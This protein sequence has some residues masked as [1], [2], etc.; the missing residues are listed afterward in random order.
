AIY[1]TKNIGYSVLSESKNK[2]KPYAF[3]KAFDSSALDNLSI[4]L[5][6]GR[7]PLNDSEILIP[8]HL[9]TNGR[10]E[11]KVGDTLTLEVGKR[12]STEDNCELDQ[13][14]P[15][16]G[17]KNPESIVD[18][19]TKEYKIVGIIER[20]PYTIEGYTAPGYTF[21]TYLDSKE[22]T[23]KIDIYTRYTKKA[24]DNEADTTADI[25]DVNHDAF[26]YVYYNK[27]MNFNVE[28]Y[29]RQLEIMGEL[30]YTFDTNDYLI[31]LE[32]GIFN[33]GSMKAL[34]IVAAIVVAIIIFTSVFCIKNSFNI[35]ITEKIKQYGMLSTIGATSKQIKKNVYSEALMLGIVGVPL[36][37]L[38][39]LFASFVLIILSN[40]LIGETLGIELIYSFSW[41]AILFAVIL[42]FITLYLSAWGSARKASKISPITAIRNSEDI[43]IN[44]K[45]VK[46]PKY[47]K[48]IFGVGGEVSYKSL[49]RNK[50][51]CRATGISI[52]GCSSVFI[53][54]SAFINLAF[55]YVK[56]DFES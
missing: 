33:D 14:N 17:E 47:I 31:I 25:L 44:A 30:K 3:I 45:K 35:S 43:K 24:L 19:V 46:S 22:I 38:C 28:E 42:G 2:S 27:D 49:K 15:Y 41:L 13:S 18:T 48:K 53:A 5:T 10:V 56:R 54:L 29:K 20:P 4:N 39:G 1:F 16:N 51:N 12:F 32:T 6:S 8:T 34:G 23:G 36:G 21:V 26:K 37:I 11:Y 9:K 7:L 40:F 55:D 52:I 50:R